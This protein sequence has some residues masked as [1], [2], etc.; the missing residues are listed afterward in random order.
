MG[1]NT[2]RE[3]AFIR[4]EDQVAEAYSKLLKALY[5]ELRPA[6]N[7]MP[8]SEQPA[9]FQRKQYQALFIRTCFNEFPDLHD[10]FMEDVV[11]LQPTDPMETSAEFNEALYTWCQM[12]NLREKEGVTREW[13]MT[14]VGTIAL[15]LKEGHSSKG[16]LQVEGA[17]KYSYDEADVCFSFNY[18]DWQAIN[19]IR[20]ESADKF[21]RALAGEVCAFTQKQLMDL[22]NEGFYRFA[23]ERPLEWS[24]DDKMKWLAHRVV[25]K[26]TKPDIVERFF[27]KAGRIYEHDSALTEV[28]RTTLR[29]AKIV[30]IA[31]PGTD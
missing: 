27:E 28:K 3:K 9:D 31:I 8:E 5:M 12:F 1:I 13:I 29:L 20:D 6:A 10:S 24:L 16:A 30:N 14:H 19:D 2:K 26:R 11:P 23:D 15:N 4:F 22:K 18:S 7:N 21:I 25:K 17:A